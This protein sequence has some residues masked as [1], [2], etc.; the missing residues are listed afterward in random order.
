MSQYYK[1]SKKFLGPSA[2][3]YRLATEKFA[4]HLKKIEESIF[5][6]T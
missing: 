4:N 2:E 6:P 5:N 1:K 3:S